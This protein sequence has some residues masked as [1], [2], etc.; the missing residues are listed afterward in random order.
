MRPTAGWRLIGNGWDGASNGFPR[1]APISTLIIRPPSRRN[2]S[3]LTMIAVSHAPYG[4]LA[5]YRKRMG[6]SFKWI[7]S[8]GTDFNF[9]YQASFTPE[10]IRSDHDR[11]VAC[12][13]RQAGGL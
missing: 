8:N 3:D 6:W 5:A 10:Q 9:D 1:T 13:L 4:R 7:S 11:G 12:A 2:R